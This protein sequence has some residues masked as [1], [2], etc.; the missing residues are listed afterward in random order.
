MPSAALNAP[1]DTMTVSIVKPRPPPIKRYASGTMRKSTSCFESTKLTRGCTE[2][3]LETS[4][5]PA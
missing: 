1:A 4:V 3:A 2:K 5:A